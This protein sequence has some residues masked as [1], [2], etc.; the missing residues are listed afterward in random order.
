MKGEL[1]EMGGL[2]WRV[3]GPDPIIHPGY[4]IVVTHVVHALADTVSGGHEV[5]AA[6]A[7]SALGVLPQWV[8]ARLDLHRFR[9][10]RSGHMKHQR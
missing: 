8:G 1:A 5:A 9:S 10:G 4:R 2:L 3:T 6:A 7:A